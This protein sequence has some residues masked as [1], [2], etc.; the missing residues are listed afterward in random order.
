MRRTNHKKMPN[1][2]SFSWIKLVSTNS[3]E[4][5]HLNDIQRVKWINS[6]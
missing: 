3:L 4:K 1:K 6:E 2:G 5:A